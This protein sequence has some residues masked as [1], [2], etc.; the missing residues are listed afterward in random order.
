MASLKK[1]LVFHLAGFLCL[2]L[3]SPGLAAKEKKIRAHLTTIRWY[4]SGEAE[5]KSMVGSFFAKAVSKPI[6]GK[7]VGLIAPHAGLVYSGQCAA[8]GFKHLEK[9]KNVER[10]ILLGVAHRG[11]FYGASVSDFQFNS[12]PMGLIPVDTDIT[13]KLAGEK[14]FKKSNSSMQQEHS[15]E[16][17]LPFLQFLQMKLKNNKYKIVPILFSYLDQKDFAKAAAVIK[18]YVTDKTLVIA[19]SDFTHY[20]ANYG[21]LPFR[22]DVKANLTR[23]D[24][25]MID[26]IK[27]LD[28]QGYFQYKK[29]TGITMCGFTPVGVLMSIFQGKGYKGTLTDYYKSGDRGNDYSLSVSYASIVISLD[30]RS[31]ASKKK[32]NPH[33]NGLISLSE[34]D[35]KA[36]LVMARRTL[37]EHFA[38]RAVP[39]LD[40]RKKYA[41]SSRLDEK[42]GV[43]VTLRKQGHL[44]GCIGTIVGQE[45]LCDG[46]QK[47]ALKAA[48]QDPR[49]RPLQKKELTDIDMEISV[50]TPLQRIGDYKNIRL[51]TDGVILRKGFH[52]AV[53]LPQVATETGWDLDR[54][55]GQLCRKAGLP[56]DAYRSE[57]M[58]FYI[59]Q[60]LVFD[61]KELKLR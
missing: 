39:V 10:V 49:F 57:G 40:I 45:P 37:E 6:P 19:S 13:S 59:F 5:L 33:S 58:D 60:A 27:E 46:V 53:F 34:A 9:I 42:A 50:M 18:K 8:N 3:C 12:T 11:G 52:Q 15:L 23:L 38:G 61:E 41:V 32:N 1:W 26:R 35:K 55:L 14:L 54:F 22:N 24:M 29:K 28:L 48:F 4:P 43:F 51:G 21:Y 56:A 36:L 31:N 20:G 30:R 47:N 7:P 17:L 25:G 44:R 16:N 2:A